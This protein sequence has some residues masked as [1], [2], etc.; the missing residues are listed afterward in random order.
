MLSDPPYFSRSAP[1]SASALLCR[2]NCSQDARSRIQHRRTAEHE[3]YDGPSGCTVR[4]MQD[5]GVLWR[6]RGVPHQVRNSPQS[7]H[8][9]SSRQSWTRRSQHSQECKDPCTRRQCF[10]DSWPWLVTFWPRNK[11]LSRLIKFGG[12][13]CISFW[14]VVQ[15]NRETDRRRRKPAPLTAV[16]M[17]NYMRIIGLVCIV[18]TIQEK[19]KCKY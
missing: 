12:P 13:S 1:L 3:T 11:W 4:I 7:F 14:D 10:C 2:E 8:L 9:P 19:V 15:K 16:G 17:G 6:S 18:Q 5:Q